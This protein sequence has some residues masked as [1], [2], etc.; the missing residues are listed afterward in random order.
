MNKWENFNGEEFRCAVFDAV[1]IK[2][3]IMRTEIKKDRR[4]EDQRKDWFT[5]RLWRSGGVGDGGCRRVDDR[6]LSR[7]IR[8][9]GHVV[10]YVK[11]G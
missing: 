5:S 3:A 8:P 11:R 7:D 2:E 10:V 4:V 1:K 9:D 6:R